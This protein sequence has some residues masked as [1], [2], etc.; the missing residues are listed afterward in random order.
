[1]IMEL[2]AQL[3]TCESA[4]EVE[5]VLQI[6][7]ANGLDAVVINELRI[8]EHERVNQR[9]GAVILAEILEGVL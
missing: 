9:I 2:F 3:E 1:M 7:R 5:A 8:E 4:D 6:A